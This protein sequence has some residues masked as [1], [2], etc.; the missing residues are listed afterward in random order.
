MATTLLSN[1]F[2]QLINKKRIR[3][4]EFDRM[5]FGQKEGLVTKL[6][7]CRHNNIS[8]PFSQGKTA[9]RVCLN[10]GARKQFNSKTLQTHGNFYFPPVIK[11]LQI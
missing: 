5:V 10:C 8:R 2:Q 6:F 11:D 9:Y 7:G 3:S 4:D 1:K